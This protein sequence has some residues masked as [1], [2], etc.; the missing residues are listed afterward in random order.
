MA[1]ANMVRGIIVSFLLGLSLY[2]H[3]GS[4]PVL[5]ANAFTNFFLPAASRVARPTPSIQSPVRSRLSATTLTRDDLD[6]TTTK[7]TV[8]NSV[9]NNNKVT[10]NADDGAVGGAVVDGS[11]TILNRTPGQD[12]NTLFDC[13]PSV[14]FW[15]DFQSTGYATSQKNIRDMFDIATRFSSLGS[16]GTLYFARHVARSGYF[17]VNALLGNFAF[18]VH[19]RFISNRPN[20]EAEDARFTGMLSNL[21]SVAATRLILEALICYEQDYEWI[22]LGTYK[23]PWDMQIGHR[24]S[25]P[26]QVATQ[27]GRFIREAVGTLARRKRATDND[28]KVSFFGKGVTNNYPS[29]NGGR[30]SVVND[31]YPSYYQNAFHYQ[32]DGWM[33]S[34]S[35]NV[36]ETSTETLFLGRQ[37]SMQRTSLVPIMKLAK[38]FEINRPPTPAVAAAAANSSGKS[39]PMRILEVAC[40]TGRFMTF[41][42]DNLPLDAEYTA[43]DLSPFYLEK[44]RDND[45]Y[46]RQ[47]QQRSTPT[48]TKTEIPSSATLVQGQ[49]EQLP[50]DDE[51]FD[52]VVCV[53]LFHEIPRDVRNKVAKEMAR[54]TAPG[55][56]VVFTDSIQRGDRPQLDTN[57][58]NFESFNEPYYLDYIADDVSAH[59]M[60][61]GLEPD[62]KMVR[63]T[64]KSLAFQKPGQLQ[65]D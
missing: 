40:G 10:G 44:A 26:I 8:K 35:A 47:Q 34:D 28:K 62:T 19:E 7:T 55:G 59:F 16:T 2:S 5:A 3:E 24:Q 56:T 60:E 20:G 31:L 11:A 17:I 49:A 13:D 9:Q 46:W 57:L 52:V 4:N 64:T 65:M 33:S 63:S 27:T 21:N 58:G 15:R 43:L 37:D 14:Q 39:R 29:S 18:D 48:A 32:T 25:N 6:T 36:Y 30:K 41:V 50:F 42:R 38:K 23:E 51:S 54:V 22:R 61:A 53:Y 45:S 12:E 1:K